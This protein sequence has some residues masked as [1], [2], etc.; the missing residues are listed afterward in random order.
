VL[1]LLAAVLTAVLGTATGRELL[2]EAGTAIVE[3]VGHILHP[4]F[5]FPWMRLDP[6]DSECF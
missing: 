1:A 3:S 4:H 6:T 2:T 5:T